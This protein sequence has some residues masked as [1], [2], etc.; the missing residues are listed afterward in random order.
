[1]LAFLD[2]NGI[3][4]AIS[5]QIALVVLAGSAW[6]WSRARVPLQWPT[7]WRRAKCGGVGGGR[8]GLEGV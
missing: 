5:F 2:S 7:T 6:V 1:M 4:P 3:W 8:E